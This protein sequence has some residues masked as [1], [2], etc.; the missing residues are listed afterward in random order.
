METKEK[1][2]DF[3]TEI[4]ESSGWPYVAVSA[5]T[6][7]VG[8]YPKNELNQLYK[9]GKITVHESAKG[10]LAKLIRKDCTL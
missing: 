9:E 10:K 6:N 8:Y 7:L 2:L 4:Y 5:I 1:I 3:M